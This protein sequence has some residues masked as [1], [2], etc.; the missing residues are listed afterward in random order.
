[1][2][3]TSTILDSLSTVRKRNKKIM[4]KGDD[5]WVSPAKWLEGYCRGSKGRAQE[6]PIGQ[7]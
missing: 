2:H 4:I 1:M 5:L 7:P 6:K 3:D